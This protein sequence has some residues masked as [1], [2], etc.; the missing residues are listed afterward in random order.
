MAAHPSGHHHFAVL[1]VEE[2]RFAISICPGDKPAP[3]GIALHQK[4]RLFLM[5]ILRA[6]GFKGAVLEAFRNKR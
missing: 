5:L 3:A 6:I 2:M 1:G 4:Q